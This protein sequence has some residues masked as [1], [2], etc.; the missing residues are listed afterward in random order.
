MKPVKFPEQNCDLG[1]PTNMTK[2]ECGSLPVYRDGKQCI[3]KWEL[4][5]EDKKHIL[6][7]GYIWL[8]VFGG[9]T[10]PPVWIDAND[11]IFVKPED[12]N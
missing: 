10:Q 7:K 4:N 3:S 11:D 2:E 6:E 9:H 5:E 8:H 1:R 12:V